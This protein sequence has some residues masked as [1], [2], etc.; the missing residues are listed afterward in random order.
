MGLPGEDASESLRQAPIISSLPLTMLK[1]HQ[2]QIIKRHE[3]SEDIQRK[4]FSFIY[5]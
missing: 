2:M 5:C 1:I 3:I 4:A